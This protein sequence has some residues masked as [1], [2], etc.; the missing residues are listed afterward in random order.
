LGEN[1]ERNGMCAIRIKYTRRI[2]I[3]GIA[4]IRFN[5]DKEIARPFVQFAQVKN[6]SD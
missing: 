3:F 6:D 2:S 4:K 1:G 5:T